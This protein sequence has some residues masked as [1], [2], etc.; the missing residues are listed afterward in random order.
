MCIFKKIN[1]FLPPRFALTLGEDAPAEV[2]A[3]QSVFPR[4]LHGTQIAAPLFEVGGQ[5][6][7]PR[8]PFQSA[9]DLIDPAR[10]LVG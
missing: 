8:F 9:T 2:L 5:K 1:L 7:Y 6:L 3:V 10:H 4:K